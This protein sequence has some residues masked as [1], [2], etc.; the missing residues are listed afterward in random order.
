MPEKASHIN[1]NTLNSYL[2]NDMAKLRAFIENVFQKVVQKVGYQM[3]DE[4]T[5]LV[6]AEEGKVYKKKY[7]WAFFAKHIIMVY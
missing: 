7:L 6:G 1:N 2:H 3:V 5:E 4:T